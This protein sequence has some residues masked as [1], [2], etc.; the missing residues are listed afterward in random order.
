MRIAFKLMHEILTAGASW[1][2]EHPL[3]SY[4]FRTREMQELL[5]NPRVHT[6]VLDQCAFGARWRKSTR[7][8]FGNVCEQD[9]MS[10]RLRCCGKHGMCSL[11]RKRH[12]TLQGRSSSGRNLAE[13]A[14][15][16]PPRLYHA[17]AKAL[18]AATFAK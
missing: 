9:T 13:E 17:L 18:T 1:G 8:V 10:L 11:T 6:L 14:A 12:V 16:Y 7:F 4:V 5:A 15:A 2:F 3:N